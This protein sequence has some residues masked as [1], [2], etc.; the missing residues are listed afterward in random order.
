VQLFVDDRNDLLVFVFHAVSG[1]K[2]LLP[3]RSL[4]PSHIGLRPS[5]CPTYCSDTIG[6]S[7]CAGRI[8][9]G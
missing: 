2:F 5:F 1:K 3:D 7:Q 4:Y 6:R 8:R 9:L